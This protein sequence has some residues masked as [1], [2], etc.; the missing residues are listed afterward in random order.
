MMQSKWVI[1]S[2]NQ[3]NQFDCLVLCCFFFCSVA[4]VEMSTR[5]VGRVLSVNFV[6]V[7][8]SVA[9]AWLT[10]CVWFYCSGSF[11]AR[12]TAFTGM[13]REETAWGV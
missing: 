11:N 7:D 12:G 3:V 4:A 10:M 6:L 2:L 13:C 1:C 5:E 9:G 8:V